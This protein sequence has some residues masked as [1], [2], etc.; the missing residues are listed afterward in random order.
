MSIGTKNR[1]RRKCGTPGCHKQ[2]RPGQRLKFCIACAQRLER[3]RLEFEAET[4]SRGAYRRSDRRGYL[5]PQCCAPGCMEPR[6]RE[7]SFCAVCR[8]MGVEEEAA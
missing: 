1:G 5:A 2:A 3:I 7:H 4:Q 8:A 6:R